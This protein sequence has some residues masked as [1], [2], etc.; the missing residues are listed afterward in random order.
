MKNIE[1]IYESIKNKFYKKTKL[2]IA[3]G[4][5]L[6]SFILASSNGL[7]DAYKE[8]EKNKNPYL[9][10]NLKG[11]D[12]DSVGMLVGCTRRENE[13]DNNYLY[14]MLSW[15]TSNQ[16]SNSTAINAALQ[17][18]EF[19]SNATHIPLTYGVGTAT[20][21]IIPKKLDNKT[22]SL[23][24]NEV[25]NRLEKVESITSYI[26]YVVPKMLPVDISCYISILKD[27]VNVKQNIE[28]KIE[29]YINNIAPGDK[30][31]IGQ[32]N[33]IG[34]NENNVSYF[35]ISTIIINGKEL[36]DISIIQ[37]LE[38]KLLFNKINWNM[39]VSN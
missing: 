31:E 22:I 21:Y 16:A 23:A 11:S 19:S 27:E 35:S 37:K 6:D 4:S 3:K 14:R 8:I 26:E 18:L 1:E 12:I 38:E 10:T 20:V 2:D 15:N 29:K 7:E 33:K 36:D 28:S 25:K 30:M 24:I 17:D 9:F 39:V 5:V 32:L 34:I 13:S